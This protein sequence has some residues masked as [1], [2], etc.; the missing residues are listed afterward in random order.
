MARQSG[1]DA[2]V[3]FIESSRGSQSL[4]PRTASR[5]MNTVLLRAFFGS[6]VGGALA[7]PDGPTG[8]CDK[9]QTASQDGQDAWA[10]CSIPD[11]K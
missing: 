6:Q 9:S 7:R 11:S 3:F 4:A 5:L 1:F 2:S 8:L 10:W